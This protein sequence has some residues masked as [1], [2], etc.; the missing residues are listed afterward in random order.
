MITLCQDSRYSSWSWYTYPHKH[1]ALDSRV[2][3]TETVLT[4]M[5]RMHS[6]IAQTN[7]LR[8]R[9]SHATQ[10]S[11]GT[12]V[13]IQ[14]TGDGCG[15]RT[16]PEHSLAFDGN[17]GVLSHEHALNTLTNMAWTVNAANG[18]RMDLS[19]EHALN[20]QWR[21]WCG[22]LCTNMAWTVNAADADRADLSHEHALNT[23]SVT[24]MVRSS[25][26]NMAWTVNAA[27]A[28]RADLSHEHAL[29]T[30]WRRFNF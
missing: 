5:V 3:F 28:D 6:S 27:D 24:D 20:T 7:M 14:L 13:A 2:H 12:Q 11:P 29:N 15:P 21:R 26:T 1:Y 30:Q 18:D 19:H 4:E 25:L 10:S 9:C 22:S 16:C 23:R 8:R 17:G